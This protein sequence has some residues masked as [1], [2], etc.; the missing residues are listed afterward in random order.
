[1]EARASKRV[2]MGKG[3]TPQQLELC[4]LPLDEVPALPSYRSVPVIQ[5][6]HLTVRAVLGFV[7]F[8][9]QEA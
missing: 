3:L 9:I 1:M 5:S 7:S 8:Q 4:A 6:L 2:L